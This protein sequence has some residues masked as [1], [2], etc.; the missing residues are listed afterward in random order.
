M[1]EKT[2]RWV[3]GRPKCDKIFA[4]YLNFIS[5]TF[6][7][8]FQ[9]SSWKIMYSPASY[10]MKNRLCKG[11]TSHIIMLSLFLLIGSQS[12]LTHSS[13]LSRINRRHQIIS[14]KTRICRSGSNGLRSDCICIVFYC[15]LVVTC[16][17]GLLWLVMMVYCELWWWFIIPVT[18]NYAC[19]DVLLW[20][21]MVFC[22]LRGVRYS[23][24]GG[25]WSL[26]RV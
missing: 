4:I 5:C 21:V 8:W 20:I 7:M 14:L 24:K 25:S 13:L 19:D 12:C 10:T 2:T 23:E 22:E 15:D 11:K 3:L 6:I 26:C 16:D 18:Y 17:D 9:P 1:H